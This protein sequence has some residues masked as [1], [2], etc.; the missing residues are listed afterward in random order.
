MDKTVFWCLIET[1]KQESDG[2]CEDQVE[3]LERKLAVLPA[4]EIIAFDVILDEF[5]HLAYRWDLWGAAYAIN[6]GCSDDGFEYF[7]CWLIAQGQKV[8]EDA[9]RDPDTLA[10]VVTDDLDD[11]ECEALM[12]A[13]LHAYEAKTGLEMPHPAYPPTEP[14]GAKL[15]E[16]DLAR[17]SEPAGERWTEDDLDRL[18]PKLCAKIGW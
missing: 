18:L 1:A 3:I 15:T 10:Q 4:D 6:G 5:R 7:R 16:E 8:F 13:A 12:Y 14:I 17:L 9:L 11:A 2:I